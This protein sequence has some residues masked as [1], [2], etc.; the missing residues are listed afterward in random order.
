MDQC[1][2]E[3]ATVDAAQV[4]M[5]AGCSQQREQFMD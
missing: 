3:D 4:V 1:V 5:L 2:V